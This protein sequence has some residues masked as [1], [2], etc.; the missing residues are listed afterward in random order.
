MSSSDEEKKPID[1][2]F[3]KTIEIV[4]GEDILKDKELLDRYENVIEKREENLKNGKAEDGCGKYGDDSTTIELMLYIRKLMRE[5]KL[6]PSVPLENY[7]QSQPLTIENL[8][9]FVVLDGK[10]RSWLTA[11]YKKEYPISYGSEPES[12]SWD[13][14]DDG[15]DYSKYL[16]ENSLNA[17]KEWFFEFEDKH[18]H[19]DRLG[20]IYYNELDHYLTYL[21][22]ALRTNKKCDRSKKGVNIKKDLKNK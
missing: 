5:E 21:V 7:I 1:D 10:T 9:N 14:F 17:D 4:F 12:H 3:E 20:H 8:K 11:R 18:G 19:K 6:I 16:E 13:Y 15:W 22:Y 2:K